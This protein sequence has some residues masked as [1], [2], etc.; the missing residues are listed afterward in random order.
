MDFSDNEKECVI[1]WE[2]KPTVEENAKPDSVKLP[3]TFFVESAVI[4]MRT[5]EMWKTLSQT[6]KKFRKLR[7]E[8]LHCFPFGSIDFVDIV[9][10]RMILANGN[11]G[12]G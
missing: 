12:C 2:K 11:D 4:L 8:C 7:E 6:F 5:M 10:S 9:S 3:P 1:V